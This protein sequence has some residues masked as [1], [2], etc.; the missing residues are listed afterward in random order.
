[1]TMLVVV[2]DG[3]NALFTCLISTDGNTSSNTF[4]IA[5]NHHR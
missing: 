1:M 2:F 4:A 5:I 3:G